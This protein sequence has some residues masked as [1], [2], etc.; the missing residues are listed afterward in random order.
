MLQRERWQR[1]VF[2]L[3]EFGL[4]E[5]CRLGG[6]E[7][8]MKQE[9]MNGE[10]KHQ[11]DREGAVKEEQQRELLKDHTEQTCQK[12]QHDQQQEKPAPHREL[13]SIHCG[14]EEAEEEKHSRCEFMGMDAGQRDHDRDDEAEEQGKRQGFSHG[15]TA[16]SPARRVFTPKQK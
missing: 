3:G 1:L 8:F 12:R 7:L 16:C 6:K 10:E 9:D 13:L 4:S 11:R 15:C 14:V 5:R 2:S